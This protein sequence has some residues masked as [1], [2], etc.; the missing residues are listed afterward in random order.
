METLDRINP[1][2]LAVNY[3]ADDVKGDGLTHGMYLLLQQYLEG[4]PHKEHIISA[5]GIINAL[6]GRKTPGEVEHIK[7][8]IDL[9]EEIF[10]EAG[11]FASLGKT[12]A[13]VA[14]FVHKQTADRGLG[15]AWDPHGCPI[16]NTGPESAMGHGIP[17]ELTIQPGHLFHIDL[18]VRYEGFCSDLQRMW[19]VLEKGETQP[20]DSVKRAL[21]TIIKAITEST[22]AIKPG[23]VGW[24]I[25]AIARDVITGAGYPEFQHGLGHSVGRSVHDGGTGLFP[26]WDKYGQTPYGK[27]EVGNVFTVE[28][29][30]ADVDGHGCMGLEEMIIVTEEGCEFLSS[31]QTALRILE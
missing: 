27:L 26:R 31:P 21:D 6:R 4:T 5:G 14:Q 3:S 15:L 10:D 1:A 23:A 28:P 18:G 30:I 8:A 16:V 12:E 7:K 2:T 20:P 19:Y 25:D 22:K 17:S 29:S 11:K 13:A 24:E 9:A